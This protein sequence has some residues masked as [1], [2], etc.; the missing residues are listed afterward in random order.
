MTVGIAAKAEDGHAIVVMLD[1]QRTNDVS[2]LKINDVDVKGFPL[3]NRWSLFYAGDGTFANSVAT[4]ANRLLSR[5][6]EEG[7]AAPSDADGIRDWV[8]TAYQTVYDDQIRFV[9]FGPH[10][11]DRQKYVDRTYD[12]DTIREIEALEE[13]YKRENTADLLVCG[14]DADGE[15]QIIKIVPDHA[16]E[17]AGSIAAIGTGQDVAEQQLAYRKTVMSERLPRVVYEVFEAKV[18][19]ENAYVGEPTDAFVLFRLGSVYLS[20][21]TKDELRA[22]LRRYDSAPIDA[23]SFYERTPEEN[24]RVGREGPDE[25]VRILT[26]QK[27]GPVMKQIEYARGIDR[28]QGVQVYTAGSGIGSTPSSVP[29][30]TVLPSS[31]LPSDGRR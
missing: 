2:G 7:V 25:W 16:G 1:K 24:A 6:A 30:E 12:S 20:D 29:I 4:E 22:A 15:G 17:V 9:V 19:A 18:H 5:R 11:Y 26:E 3:D 21:N 8:R 23:L 28:G 10:S 13:E 31:Q 27:L 14:F